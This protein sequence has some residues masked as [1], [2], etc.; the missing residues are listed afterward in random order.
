MAEELGPLAGVRVLDL[1]Q[2]LAGPY[3]TMMLGDLG[4]DV[5]KVERPGSGDG[6]R[7]WGPPFVGDQAAYFLCVNRNKRSLTLDL[8]QPRGREIALELADRSDVLV[9]NFRPG[10]AERLGLAW[11]DVS[12]RNPRLVYCAL[13]SFGQNGPY[14]QRKG[15]DALI[16]GMGGLMSITGPAGGEPVKV[17]VAIV[18]VLAGLFATS[19]ILSALVARSRTGL[20]QQVDVALLDS[21]VAALVN[22]A[23]AYL[24]TGQPPGRLGTAHPSIVPYQAFQASDS[25]FMVAV[26]NDLQFRALAAII[27]RPEL[28]DD[29]RFATNPARVTHREELCELLAAAFGERPAGE[30]IDA[31]LASGIPAGPIN[32][33]DAVFQDVQ[34]KHREMLAQVEHPTAGT[35]DL[36][37][38]PL[39]LSRDPVAVRRRPPCLGE[40]CEEILREILQ[41]DEPAIA[42]LRG[43]KVL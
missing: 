18:D 27:G 38:S 5:I 25:F 12:A 19:G 39:K 2:I 16:Q 42:E 13:S 37:G 24:V 28:G 40:H 23:Q 22:Q 43:A 31:M 4:A 32:S 26:G 8:K 35:I 11:P 30:W 17:G 20:G 29:P 9:H 33:L 10:V 7:A 34:V 41:L 3:C 14:A 36:V 15:Y 21:L 1:S 6:T